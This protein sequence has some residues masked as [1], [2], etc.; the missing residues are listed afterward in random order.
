ML[1]D[2]PFSDH[3]VDSFSALSLNETLPPFTE[4][5]LLH[6]YM[7][8]LNEAVISSV[9]Q[10]PPREPEPS[11]APLAVKLVPPVKGSVMLH[12]YEKAKEAERKHLGPLSALFLPLSSRPALLSMTMEDS[13]VSPLSHPS[14]RSSS[15]SDASRKSS[16]SGTVDLSSVHQGELL[17]LLQKISSLPNGVK[18]VNE[19]QKQS[20]EYNQKQQAFRQARQEC[21]EETVWNNAMD[22]VSPEEE[23]E[24][25]YR[26]MVSMRLEYSSSESMVQEEIATSDASTPSSSIPLPR[27]RSGAMPASRS[28]YPSFRVTLNSSLSASGM[29]LDPLSLQSD[30]K[31]EVLKESDQESSLTGL[32]NPSQRSPSMDHS[33]RFSSQ[34]IEESI[35]RS[36]Q[37]P[38]STSIQVLHQSQPLPSTRPRDLS[39]TNMGVAVDRSQ[40]EGNGSSGDGNGNSGNY[41]GN[42]DSGNHDGNGSTQDV[43]G[44]SA[45]HSGSGSNANH[46]PNEIHSNDSERHPQPSHSSTSNSVQSTPRSPSSIRG[47]SQTSS[48]RPCSSETSQRSQYRLCPP[49][50]GMYMVV[51]AKSLHTVLEKG[52]KHR[53]RVFSQQL[54]R[55]ETRPS[56][57]PRK[58]TEGRTTLFL[59]DS[60][61][62]VTSR[63]SLLSESE[64]PL[65]I[66]D[67]TSQPSLTNMSLDLGEP[68]GPVRVTQEQEQEQERPLSSCSAFS[69]SRRKLLLS[70]SREA[71][72]PEAPPHSDA[73]RIIIPERSQSDVI[74]PSVMADPEDPK[75]GGN[76]QPL[77]DET[78]NELEEIF[79]NDS[80]GELF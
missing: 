26:P 70:Q 58:Q 34:S 2:F 31:G 57:V 63:D 11:T 10:R 5:D 27:L 68:E 20:R 22:Y 14:P 13:S 9:K 40:S 55:P 45:S 1:D 18:R 80:F 33:I 76:Y 51:P 25:S 38:T 72:N 29:R 24:F 8:N 37:L 69:R 4:Q 47:H 28:N 17:V 54:R 65:P 16:F 77:D 78:V 43:N 19:L 67:T 60:H 44:S 30:S 7:A 75:L 62:A 12:Y 64:S 49:P 73:Q 46:D 6:P 56:E 35:R 39:L 3:P 36:L 66:D 50:S 48:P 61:A 59:N 74:H 41:D 32:S 53:P 71:P 42:G 52:M 15:V 79:R 21:S 23:M